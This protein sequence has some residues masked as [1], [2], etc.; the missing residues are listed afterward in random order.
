MERERGIVTQ[1]I[2]LQK[3]RLKKHRGSGPQR[4]LVVVGK[5]VDEALASKPDTHLY[6]MVPAETAELIKRVAKYEQRTA[7][8]VC[9]SWLHLGARVYKHLS[10][11][12]SPYGPPEQDVTA[13]E[14]AAV[15]DEIKMTAKK[16]RWSRAFTDAAG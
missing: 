13:D 15:A 6:F 8:T 4:R 9:R 11:E 16:H 14:I 5:P 7:A 1:K 3:T 2:L 10:D 12:L